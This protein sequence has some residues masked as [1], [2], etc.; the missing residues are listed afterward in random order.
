VVFRQYCWTAVY[1][2]VVP[3]DRPNTPVLLGHRTTTAPVG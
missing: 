1:S 2:G 3:A